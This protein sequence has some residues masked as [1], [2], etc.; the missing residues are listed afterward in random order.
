MEVFD[1]D[2]EVTGE[3]TSGTGSEGKSDQLD[4]NLD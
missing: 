1:A 2:Q 4:T 3:E